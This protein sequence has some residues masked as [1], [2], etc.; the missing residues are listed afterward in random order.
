[1]VLVYRCMRNILEDVETTELFTQLHMVPIALG[2]LRSADNTLLRETCI[3][4][5]DAVIENSMLLIER[6]CYSRGC[7]GSAP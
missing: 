1:M 4:A 2:T 3:M 6:V 7:T 5:L